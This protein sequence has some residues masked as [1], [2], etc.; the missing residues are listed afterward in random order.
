MDR[1]HFKQFNINHYNYWLACKYI[2]SDKVAEIITAFNL[3]FHKNEDTN[4]KCSPCAISRYK[5][6]LENYKTGYIDFLNSQNITIEQGIEYALAND[7]LNTTGKDMEKEF[8]DY[9]FSPLE[10]HEQKTAVD[11]EPKKRGRKPKTESK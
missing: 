4:P 3:I 7:C 11:P 1:L 2:K 10:K 5:K 8:I 9:Y 6:A